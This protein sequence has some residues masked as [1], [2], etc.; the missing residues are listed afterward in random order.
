MTLDLAIFLGGHLLGD[1]KMKK[2]TKFKT[3]N[4]IRRCFECGI[5]NLLID[6]YDADDWEGAGD[7]EITDREIGNH[8]TLTCLNCGATREYDN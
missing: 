6:E 4:S 7:A 3:D 8:G 5:S 2:K 1:L